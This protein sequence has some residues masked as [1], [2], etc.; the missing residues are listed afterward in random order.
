MP[1]RTT[2][3]H[4]CSQRVG[5][6]AMPPLNLFDQLDRP[7]ALGVEL[8][9]GGEGSVFEIRHAPD[10]VAKIYHNAPDVSRQA[11]LRAMIGMARKEIC[12]VAA[13]PTATL[14]D[15]P[16]GPVRGFVMR[17]VKGYRDV[18]FLYSPA[19]RK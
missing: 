14:H 16:N 8:G 2:T 17:K 19:H 9:K 18:H 12:S 11:K 1:E 3:K 6:P 5:F 7:V 15:R 13:W 10:S 4:S